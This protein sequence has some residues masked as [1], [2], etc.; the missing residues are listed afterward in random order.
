[1]N[2]E[3]IVP[4]LFYGDRKM[5]YC[6]RCLNHGIYLS[7]KQHKFNCRYVSCECDACKMVERR[8]I[9]NSRLSKMAM[10]ESKSSSSEDGD[11]AGSSC[12]KAFENKMPIERLPH[13]QRCAQHGAQARLKGHKKLCPYRECGCIKCQV[14]FER[15]R[16]MA[17][18]I[19]L[20]RK[21]KKEKGGKP[22]HGSSR[23][24][25]SL[26]MTS[27]SIIKQTT[28][29]SS[30]NKKEKAKELQAVS[31]EIKKED[32]A[33]STLNEQQLSSNQGSFVD[34]TLSPQQM[35]NSLLAL[36]N[37]ARLA[38]SSRS[39]IFPP[40]SLPPSCLI[41][42]LLPIINPDSNQPPFPRFNLLPHQQHYF[43]SMQLLTQSIN[44]Q[45]R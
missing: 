24:K 9:L 4:E 2:I 22:C 41:S 32:G 19:K 15:Q 37:A 36:N 17:D 13:C 10:E 39:S 12:L 27:P 44:H 5:Y 30:V 42:R 7:R 6:Q 25:E 29:P 34:S 11:F 33:R 21:Q 3:E 45:S 35:L 38:E 16:L 1:M 18:Q 28:T 8:R 14:V 26:L 31:V 20:R 43:H 23:N 40:I